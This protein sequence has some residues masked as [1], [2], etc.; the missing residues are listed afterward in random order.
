ML[1]KQQFP[2]KF[3]Y[4]G[5]LPQ[6]GFLTENHLNELSLVSSQTIQLS[7]FRAKPPELD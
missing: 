4:S 3:W 1:F 7:G 6:G 5:F 2:R